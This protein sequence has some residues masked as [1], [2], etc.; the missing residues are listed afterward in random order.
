MKTKTLPT[1]KKIIF[2]FSIQ[3][4]NQKELEIDFWSFWQNLWFWSLFFLFAF[5]Y[6]NSNLKKYWTIEFFTF[7]Q[8][9]GFD[10]CF[11]YSSSKSNGTLIFSE[12]CKFIWNKGTEPS[13]KM[14]ET[15]KTNTLVEKTILVL[16]NSVKSCKFIWKR[17][18]R[19]LTKCLKPKI[20]TL[21]LKKQMHI[22]KETNKIRFAGLLDIHVPC[23]YFPIQLCKRN[24]LELSKSLP[25]RPKCLLLMIPNS[26]ANLWNQLKA[27]N[28]SWDDAWFP[29]KGT[30][31]SKHDYSGNNR[32]RE[33]S[34]LFAIIGAESTKSRY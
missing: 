2:H 12:H 3:I 7:W 14:P 27:R 6:S 33:S 1:C 11:F 20:Q 29:P 24:S 25:K 23:I 13:Y 5:F 28:K 18:L 32:G 17:A 4:L 22:S 8:G 9:L 15:K 34:C 21:S 19:R 10:G 16:K 26:T 30:V 31:F